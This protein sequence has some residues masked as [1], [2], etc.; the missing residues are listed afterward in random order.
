MERNI[1]RWTTLTVVAQSCFLGIKLDF[2]EENTIR[3]LKGKV[4]K[5]KR[6]FQFNIYGIS[7]ALKNVDFCGVGEFD[8]INPRKF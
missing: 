2:Q 4:K 8:F 3:I 1:P 6:F 5:G 7:I